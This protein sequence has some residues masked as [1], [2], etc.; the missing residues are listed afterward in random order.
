M[1]TGFAKQLKRAFLLHSQI[2][3]YAVALVKQLLIG[4]GN[5]CRPCG[6]RH[7]FRG[8]RCLSVFASSKLFSLFSVLSPLL[9]S[10]LLSSRLSLSLSPSRESARFLQ[11]RMV[12]SKTMLCFVSFGWLLV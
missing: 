8:T 10:A 4:A 1:K 7:L 11:S 2:V 9:S 6:F 12:E 5:R 3:W